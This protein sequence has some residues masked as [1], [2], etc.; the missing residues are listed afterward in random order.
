MSW[1]IST[2]Q[3][4]GFGLIGFDLEIKIIENYLFCLVT[5]IYM[6]F[7]TLLIIYTNVVNKL[8]LHNLPL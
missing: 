4:Q 8:A 6:H 2:E 5:D 7:V 3:K 1:L